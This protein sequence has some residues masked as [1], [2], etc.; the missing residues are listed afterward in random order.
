MAV[1]QTLVDTEFQALS[2]LQALVLSHSLERCSDT[3]M[4]GRVVG[5]AGLKPKSCRPCYS[6]IHLR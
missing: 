2:E 6:A 4:V 5:W 1:I 3:H